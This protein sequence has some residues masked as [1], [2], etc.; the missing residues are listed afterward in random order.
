LSRRFFL[1]FLWFAQPILLPFQ[2]QIDFLD[3]FFVSLRSA[4]VKKAS[5]G[6]LTRLVLALPFL[7]V[8]SRMSFGPRNSLDGEQHHVHYQ[9]YLLQ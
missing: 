1:F 8:L 4:P 3:A 7:Q 2:P 5:Q 6:L 9:L